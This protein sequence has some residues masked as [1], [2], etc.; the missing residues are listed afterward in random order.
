MATPTLRGSEEVIN[1]YGLVRLRVKG[2][3]QLVLNIY[4]LD[5]VDV[6]S[7]VAV[8]L[9]SATNIEPTQL[10][11]LTEHRAKLEIRTMNIN[12]TFTCSKI[13]VFAKPVATSFPGN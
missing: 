11:N 13:V 10:C 12:E 8:P 5:E 3:A 4:S 9:Q 1:H 6:F 2:S 7:M